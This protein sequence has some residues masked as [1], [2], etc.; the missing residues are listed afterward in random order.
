MTS[1]APSLDAYKHLRAGTP[2]ALSL[3]ERPEQSLANGAVRDVI[4]WLVRA[5]A[6]GHFPVGST[7]PMENELGE[8][9]G[10]SRTVI[11]EAV[12]ILTDKGVLK[13]ARR[14]GTVVNA[15]ESWNLLDADIISWHEPGDAATPLIFREL[16]ELLS[17]I[18]PQA[19]RAASGRLPP[20]ANDLA[21]L[22]LTALQDHRASIEY[23]VKA[24]YTLWWQI[25]TAPQSGIFAQ[26]K[27]LTYEMLRLTYGLNDRHEAMDATYRS[28][29]QSV[30]KN[31]SDEV[32]LCCRLILKRSKHIF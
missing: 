11:R 22:A 3:L 1:A 24:E 32:D 8:R 29:I 5:I 14:Y 18:L 19:A 17:M 15:L 16:V 12:K 10:V 28:L 31:D 23:R 7:L 13:T 4:D 27:G 21:E 9:V 20:H 30:G 26:F 2:A 6:T 25:L